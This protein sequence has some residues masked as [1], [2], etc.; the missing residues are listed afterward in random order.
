MAVNAESQAAADPE[1][2]E[3]R[4]WQGHAHW[5]EPTGCLH[6]WPTAGKQGETLCLLPL[7]YLSVA[8][9]LQSFCKVRQPAA[10]LTCKWHYSVVWKD[11]QTADLYLLDFEQTQRHDFAESDA[12]DI[13]GH[14][15]SV[16]ARLPGSAH[17]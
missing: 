8:Q 5:N 16:Y 12:I 1:G 17:A 6:K 13:G 11:M 14:G 4:S 7:A 9:V 2:H 10:M 15:P 3:Q